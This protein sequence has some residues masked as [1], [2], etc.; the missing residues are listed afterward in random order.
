MSCFN[1][2]SELKKK[3]IGPDFKQSDFVTK[4]KL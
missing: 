1:D 3:Y 2:S 4:N